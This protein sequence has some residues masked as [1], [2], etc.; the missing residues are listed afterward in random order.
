MH[1]PAL[2]LLAL[3]DRSI[4]RED[5]ELAAQRAMAALGLA[6]T[7]S[8]AMLLA[9]MPLIS[10]GILALA[11][12]AFAVRSKVSSAARALRTAALPAPEAIVALD[13]REI[14]R[15]ILTAYDEVERGVAAARR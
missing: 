9:G 3:H 2:S 4:A 5:R 6:A 13:L 7:L 1:H 14:Y 15:A 11:G 10:M 12:M 8:I